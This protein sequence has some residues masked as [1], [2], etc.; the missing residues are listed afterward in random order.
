MQM[1]LLKLQCLF[2]SDFASLQ[3]GK[4]R[5]GFEIT[6]LR[7]S[8]IN[9]Y[10][11]VIHTARVLPQVTHILH[12]F[13]CPG[14][15][16]P[17]HV[18]VV[19]CE[20][21]VWVK[22]VARKAQA[23]HLIFNGQGQFGEKDIVSQAADYVSC[24]RVHPVNFVEPKILFAF[25]GGVTR[26]IAEE[27]HRLGVSAVGQVVDVDE[28]I[29]NKLTGLQLC[30]TD[31]DDSDSNSTEEVSFKRSFTEDP[32]NKDISEN[33]EASST[34]QNVELRCESVKSGF[35]KDDRAISHE[36]IDENIAQYTDRSAICFTESD[37]TIDSSKANI[38]QS[39]PCT[40][41]KQS[42]DVRSEALFHHNTSIDM[43]THEN[44]F[45]SKTDLQI[46]HA[47]KR[48]FILAKWTFGGES[49]LNFI[50]DELLINPLV[51]Y[52]PMVSVLKQSKINTVDRIS[53]V[54]LDVTALITLVSAVAHGGCYFRF[55]E[56][57]LSEQASEERESP[58][59]RKLTS[60]LYGKQLFACQ[61][62][63]DSFTSILE[64]LGGPG[65]KRRA[66][67]LLSRVNVVPDNTSF[68]ADVMPNTGK[69][70]DRSKV[71]FGTGDSLK[72]V[73]V[74]ANSGFV[75]AAHHQG[76]LFSVFL[77]AS[78]ALTE[79]KEKTAEAIPRG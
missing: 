2:Q 45:Q 48:D 26:I 75:R 7:S 56:K 73:T 49:M 61:T 32:Q 79:E 64:T 71:I 72:A 37:K 55:K 38:A 43:V 23:L 42:E 27:L 34:F 65:E 30:N 66:E 31:S 59:L 77:H 25:Y 14:R 24:S 5:G 62:A 53:R 22:V 78:R 67:D 9:H 18:D 58:V 10:V 11:G 51:D 41:M 15:T 36:S 21:N 29:K 35:E 12:A 46:E 47:E 57:I 54:N 3:L 52:S 20:G 39:N 40:E 6:H 33:N 74:T 60:F 13:T 28:D 68:R 8:N 19:A 16:E 63:V 17:L 4:R 70:K 50:E 1:A 44:I 69:I 76:V